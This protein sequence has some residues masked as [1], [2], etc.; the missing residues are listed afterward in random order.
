MCLG[1]PGC[2]WVC[3]G[4]PVCACV[5]L[6]VPVCACVCLCVPVCACV[7]LCVPVCA[8]V[9][10]CVP[11]CVACAW[12]QTHVRAH[13]RPFECPID[14]C[15]RRFGW[16][17]D[18]KRHIEKIHKRHFS[19]F[20]GCTNVVAPSKVDIS[21]FLE[22]A[23]GGWRSYAPFPCPMHRPA[24][25]CSRERCVRARARPSTCATDGAHALPP[26]LPQR[27]KLCSARSGCVDRPRGRR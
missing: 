16:C 9:C 11:A 22:R 27:N 13:T 19:E 20:P 8:C 25:A 24:R 14:T 5:C 4:V 21:G 23:A 18:L 15:R 2:A 7:C 3:L 17:V 26:P 10:L 1:V 12:W 6:C